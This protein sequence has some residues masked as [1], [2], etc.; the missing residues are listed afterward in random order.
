MYMRC[1]SPSAKNSPSCAASLSRKRTLSSSEAQ[2]RSMATTMASGTF[3]M[4]T[5]STSGFDS[6]MPAVKR[7]L[8]QPSSMC[9]SENGRSRPVRRPISSSQRPLCCSGAASRTEAQRSMRGCRLGFFLI[10]TFFT[11]P[12]VMIPHSAQ[13]INEEK[14]A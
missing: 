12:P 8:P 9:S 1:A 13:N 7:P 4:A 10:L 3:S 14:L 11:L 2:T 6:A 5:K